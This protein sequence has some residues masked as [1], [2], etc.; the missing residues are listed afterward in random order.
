MYCIVDNLDEISQNLSYQKVGNN[1]L[2]TSDLNKKFIL[3]LKNV[4]IPFGL[5]SYSYNK[6]EKFFLKINLD[7]YLSKKF[8]DF[9]QKIQQ[10]I[11]DKFILS[12]NIKTQILS[13]KYN[14]QLLVKFK[15][16][17]NKFQTKIYDSNNSEIDVFSLEPKNKLNI[18]ISPNIFIYNGN[19]IIKWTIITINKL[20]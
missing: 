12:L 2:I 20:R 18:E 1:I 16:F 10:D 15:E 3:I 13:K 17:R 7:N 9:E 14:N 4:C 6:K 8:N 11:N 5:E 19:I